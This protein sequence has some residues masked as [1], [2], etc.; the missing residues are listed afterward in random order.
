M[1]KKGD[2]NVDCE[3]ARKLLSAYVDKELVSEECDGVQG[4]LQTCAGCARLVVELQ[5]MSNVL[6]TVYAS[7]EIPPWNENWVAVLSSRKA[8][9]ANELKA[10]AFWTVVAMAVWTL[11]MAA[12]PAGVFFWSM[13]RLGGTLF[14]DVYTL[15]V[16]LALQQVGAISVLAL[17]ATMFTCL[18]LVSIRQ[19]L[20]NP[21][22]VEESS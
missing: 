1:E 14:R 16:H 8:L 18:S 7:I 11:G 13:V 4:H 17:L 9:Q 5:T 20:R 2:F 3:K 6:Q 22:L 19:L 12:S 21:S 15:F 10:V